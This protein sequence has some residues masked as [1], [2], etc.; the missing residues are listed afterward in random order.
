V[1]GPDLAQQREH[2]DLP[3]ASVGL[4][5]ADLEAPVGEVDVAP[6]HGAGRRGPPAAQHQ[7]GDRRAPAGRLDGR[8]LGPGA[9]VA[10]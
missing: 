10:V 6:D 8:A 1:L 5:A 9:A 4:V 7:R 2:V 3:H